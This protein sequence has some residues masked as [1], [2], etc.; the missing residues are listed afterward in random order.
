VKPDLDRISRAGLTPHGYTLAVWTAGMCCIKR[1]GL[2][3]TAAVLLFAVGATAAFGVVR[4]LAT[5]PARAMHDVEGH[6]GAV[7]AHII[8]V[9][10]VVLACW[11][12]A[13]LPS[14][15]CWPTVSSVATV[16]FIVLHAGQ[17][18]V[19][20]RWHINASSWVQGRDPDH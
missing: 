13:W 16:T 19:A 8:A 4:L 20:R 12:V 3:T 5:S 14:P 11:L 15:W 9:P 2:P 17:D 18:A 10:G 1:H 7:G 6:A